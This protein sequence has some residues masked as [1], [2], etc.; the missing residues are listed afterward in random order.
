MNNTMK[1]EFDEMEALVIQTTQLQ[2]KRQDFRSA[3]EGEVQMKGVF[4]NY[5]V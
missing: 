3:G 1:N 2:Q 4:K 5:L